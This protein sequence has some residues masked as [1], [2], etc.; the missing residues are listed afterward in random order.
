MA[1]NVCVVTHLGT[2][3]EKLLGGNGSR[4]KLLVSQVVK[5]IKETRGEK[6]AKLFHFTFVFPAFS[7]HSLCRY[8]ESNTRMSFQISSV[9][10]EGYS[11][12]KWKWQER[13]QRVG[14]D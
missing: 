4:S 2:L 13:L 5:G 3:A 12:S 9:T 6:G 11:K 10:S 8:P 1:V 14:R 7:R